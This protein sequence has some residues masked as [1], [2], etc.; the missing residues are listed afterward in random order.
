MKSNGFLVWFAM[1]AILAGYLAG[2]ADA[3]GRHDYGLAPG[4]KWVHAESEFG[5]GGISAPVRYTS[6]G[7]QIQLP[8]GTWMFCDHTCS[9]TLRLATVDFWESQNGRHGDGD[10]SC[11]LI[12]CRLKFR[13]NY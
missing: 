2:P 12:G 9:E 10:T 8:G 11:G 7:P 4:Q 6:K 5:N 1:I 3:F 13:L